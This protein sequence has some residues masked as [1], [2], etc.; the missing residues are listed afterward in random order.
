[1]PMITDD[2]LNR[3][4]VEGAISEFKKP[5]EKPKSSFVDTLGAAFSQENIISGVARAF[6]EGLPNKT[7][8]NLDFSPF[9]N[10]GE[11]ISG[12]EDFADKFVGANSEEDV[13]LIKNSIDR[14]MNNKETLANAPTWMN[15]VSHLA[16]GAADPTMLIPLVGAMTKATRTGRLIEGA[17]TGAAVGVTSGLARETG[18]QA[19]QETRSLEESGLNVLMEGALGG[20]L[21]GAVGA[22][23]SAGR[24][25]ARVDLAG[26]L[27][28]DELKI[29]VGDNKELSVQR[30]I[31]AAEAD[32]R[33]Q[34]GLA[35]I[36]ES[37]A[38]V[39][40]GGAEWLM[41]PSLRGLTSGHGV[42]RQ[43]TN[44]VFNHNFLLNKELAGDARG[45]IAENVMR[46][47]EAKMIQ[48]NSKVKSLFMKATGRKSETLAA[49]NIGRKGGVSYRQFQ[50]RISKA[51][52]DENYVDDIPE[53]R[54]A[55]DVYRA[56]MDTL[57]K[58]MEELKILP[59]DLT[60]AQ[61]RNYLSRVYD[62]KKM[63]DVGV[64]NRFIN[65]VSNY[66]REFNPDGTARATPLDD[67]DAAELA[68][69]TYENIMGEGD[70]S[71]A[72]NEVPESII[73]KGRFT[74]ERSLLMED[75]DL[76]EF[77]VNDA[78]LIVSGYHKRATS[79]IEM[80]KALND[81]GAS[82]LADFK[83]SIVAEGNQRLNKAADPKARDAIRREI[84]DD[85]KLADNMYR[86]MTGSLTKPG[87]ADRFVNALLKFQ[88]MR[89]LGGVTI[90]SMSE[91]AMAPFRHGLLNTLKD[92]YLPMMRDWRAA[93]IAKDQL[94]D[95]DVGLE[96]EVNNILRS[97]SSDEVELG[98]KTT[99]FDRMMNVASQTFGKATGLTYY[100]SFGRRI[101]SQVASADIVRHLKR[102][103]SG[104]A[105]ELDI[106]TL[107]NWGIGKAQ[108]ERVLAQIEKHVQKRNG[109]YIT[110]LHLWDDD[111][112]KDA[113]SNAIQNNVESV[114]LK[115][116]K[117][118]VP[119][120]AQSSN[121]GRL[122]FQFKSFISAATGKIGI[123]GLQRRDA[124]V[125]QGLLAL[126]VMGGLSGMVKDK[127]AG[128]EISDDPTEFI[129]EG[130][131]NS[132]VLGLLG[133]TAL[134]ISR[135]YANPS[136][137][138]FGAESV[139]GVVLGPSAT[140]IEDLAMRT[141]NLLDGNMTEKD[142]KKFAQMLPYMNLFYI[143]ILTERAFKDDK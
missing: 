82:S 41:A 18:F 101:A 17:V 110:N 142:K 140:L 67:G 114:I 74:K 120:F 65:K 88:T 35:R 107:A 115:P 77:L 3:N 26:I 109:S 49:L 83:K 6:T 125:L 98:A 27:G 68:Q 91:M 119:I 29:R 48:A 99:E 104:K 87:S 139:Q 75:K 122:A 15:V 132:G 32:I 70:Q 54:K 39:F 69:K 44:R 13:Q 81:L 78:E 23:S 84:N 89:L 21:G 2:E 80:Q 31:G 113:F 24:S 95:L 118:D 127:I 16:A 14:E 102:V 64:R 116:G 100:T 20:I 61:K 12:Y 117:G 34:E 135:V 33:D 38:R 22:M 19:T 28:E 25:A 40:G 105:S 73:A 137:R 103:K 42:M 71:F 57:V 37:F 112:A 121:I 111:V 60:A 94:K 143:R 92:G 134:D 43:F 55:A 130:I 141:G 85:V 108:H 138:R 51:L 66:Y 52:R 93:K 10:D 8:S 56:E 86:A 124:K 30:S 53:V 11:M 4:V 126:T 123:S 45:T 58:Q 62:T 76:E 59:D 131:S 79:L 128:K 136:T 96:N 9:D 46:R 7:G 50:E 72:F 90:S 36:N 63:N 5:E 97:L 1:M 129:L 106:G 133:T 47:N